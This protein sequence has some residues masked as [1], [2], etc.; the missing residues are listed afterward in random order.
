MQ[1][2]EE[3]KIVEVLSTAHILDSPVMT[4]AY[5]S[6]YMAAKQLVAHRA[7]E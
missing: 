6:I 5:V 3:V 1:K 2:Q 4:I 7:S